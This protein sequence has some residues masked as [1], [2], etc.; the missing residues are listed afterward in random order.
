[1][2]RITETELTLAQEMFA[3]TREDSRIGYEASNHYYYYPFDLAEKVVNC[4]WV[5]RRLSR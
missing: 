5:L 3:L 2:R 1:M 4:D